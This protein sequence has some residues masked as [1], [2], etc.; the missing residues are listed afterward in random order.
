MQKGEI[1]IYKTS[2][3]TEIQ[4]KLDKESVWLDAQLMASLFEVSARQL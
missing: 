2:T 4:V 1:Q 3:G